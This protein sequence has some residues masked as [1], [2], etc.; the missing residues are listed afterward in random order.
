MELWVL[1]VMVVERDEERK[2]NK[3]NSKNDGEGRTAR[4]GEGRVAHQTG[5]VDHGEL[6]DELHGVFQGCMEQEAS[7]AHK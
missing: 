7:G 2:A 1:Q 4:V 6:I 5:G 3:G